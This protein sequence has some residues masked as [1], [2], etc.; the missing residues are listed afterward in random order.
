MGAI[1]SHSS[2]RRE[3]RRDE[4]GTIQMAIQKV[5]NFL[6]L[7]YMI[8]DSVDSVK[9]VLSSDVGRTKLSDFMLHERRSR[10]LELWIEI[11]KLRMLSTASLRKRAQELYE[12]YMA[13]MNGRG[14]T[15]SSKRKIAVHEITCKRKASRTELLEIFDGTAN[16][17]LHI[18]ATSTWLRFLQSNY[19]SKWYGTKIDQY[20]IYLHFCAGDVKNG[21]MLLHLQ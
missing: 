3:Q 4:E 13:T 20:R 9:L 15:V 7:S 5:E 12:Q 21:V 2:V 11:K 10:D 16:E 19:Y 14:A 18:V 8:G 1:H 17:I 6:L